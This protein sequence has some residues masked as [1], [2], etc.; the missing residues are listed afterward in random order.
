MQKYCLPLLKISSQALGFRSWRESDNRP[1]LQLP[2]SLSIAPPRN[3]VVL[4]QSHSAEVMHVWGRISEYDAAVMLRRRYCLP[5]SD[6]QILVCPFICPG[7]VSRCLQ[8][9]RQVRSNDR[10]I[11]CEASDRLEEPVHRPVSAHRILPP[12]SGS[13]DLLS[14]QYEDAVA[15][16][17]EANERPPDQN[18]RNA[19]PERQTTAPFLL[20]GKEHE[21]ALRA[22]KKRDTDEE[23]DVAHGE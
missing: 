21:G 11:V 18:E 12:G 23:E 14:E 5:F 3:T 20:A 2:V 4:L 7:L 6:R 8:A 22:E 13:R 10:D 16:H 9:L 15:L 17:R 1:G 19:G